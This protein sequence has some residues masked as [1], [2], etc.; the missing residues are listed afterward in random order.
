MGIYCICNSS[1]SI[2][3]SSSNN[4]LF[5]VQKDQVFLARMPISNDPS[6]NSHIDYF[7]MF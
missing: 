2:R 6:K 3:S 7:Q 1:S 4:N 5:F